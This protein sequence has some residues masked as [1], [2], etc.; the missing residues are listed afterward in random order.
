[1]HWQYEW[2]NGYKN[3]TVTLANRHK[4]SPEILGTCGD[5]WIRTTDSRIFSPML[6]QLS[7][8]TVFVKS[9]AKVGF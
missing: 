9:V 4:K 6:Y 7:Y 3:A 1:M 2:M 8:I 5:E